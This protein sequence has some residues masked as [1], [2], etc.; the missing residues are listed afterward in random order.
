MSWSM[1]CL[2]TPRQA[3]PPHKNR[4]SYRPARAVVSGG[5]F[6]AMSATNAGV[7]TNPAT[8]TTQVAS[9]FMNIPKNHANS[10]RRPIGESVT[11]SAH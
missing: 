1:W 8:A 10:N 2:P 11:D 5:A 9:F 7:P 4:S 6:T 3:P